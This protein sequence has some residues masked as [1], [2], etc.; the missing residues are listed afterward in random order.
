L[1]FGNYSPGEGE[2]I[3]VT[4]SIE[5]DERVF[6]YGF[7]EDVVTTVVRELR[8]YFRDNPRTSSYRWVGK[9]LTGGA[10][11]TDIDN[12]KIHISPE[13][14]DNPRKY[15]SVLVQDVNMN[16]QDLFLG[17]I[18]GDLVIENPS[19]DPAHVEDPYVVDAKDNQIRYLEVGKRFGGKANCTVTLNIRSYQ[20]LERDRI[21]DLV[22]HGMVLPIRE[23][24][25]KNAMNFLPNTA[26]TS[27]AGVEDITETEKVYVRNFVFGL[28]VEWYEDF[29][30]DTPTI[31]D[32]STARV[33]L[34][35][36]PTT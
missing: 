23:A 18:M 4:N 14:S 31:T 17:Q 3:D 2:L 13:Y 15:P 30:Y 5:L 26:A 33:Y 32:L 27:A 29:F 8:M 9:A 35:R 12:T 21:C 28:Q 36:P 16:L 34:S 7:I 25:Y 22:I 10:N 1:G 19:Y 24:L 6:Y 20:R 11:E